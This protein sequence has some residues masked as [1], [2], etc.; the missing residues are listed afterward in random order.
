MSG[1]RRLF[2]RLALGAAMLVPTAANAR[3]FQTL[4]SFTGGRDGRFPSGAVFDNAGNLYGTTLYD[5]DSTACGDQGCGAVF[6]LAP[7]AK[8][9]TAWTET[10]YS[11]SGSPDGANPYAGVVFVNGAL[12]GT[13][14]FGGYANDTTCQG[15]CGTVFDLDPQL[16]R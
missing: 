4:Y 8:G 6:K 13:T 3:T 14:A 10:L 12:Y 11:F 1:A 5:G 7:P 16:R 9:H 2:L 15:G